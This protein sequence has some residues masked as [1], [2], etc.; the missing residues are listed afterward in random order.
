MTKNLRVNPVPR[1]T[2]DPE[3]IA[4]VAWIQAK[5]VRR[6]RRENEAQARAKRRGREQ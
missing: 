3:A 6:T 2:P 5:R 1:E 4:I